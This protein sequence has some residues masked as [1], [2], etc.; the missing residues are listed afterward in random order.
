MSVNATPPLTPSRLYKYVKPERLQDL[1]DGRI[2][3]TQ[4]SAQNDPFEFQPFYEAVASADLA[5]EQIHQEPP[6]LDA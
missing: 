6:H 4:P 1:I 2:R 5:F 3:F